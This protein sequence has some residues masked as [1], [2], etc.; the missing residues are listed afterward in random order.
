MPRARE[1]LFDLAG[2]TLRRALISRVNGRDLGETSLASRSTRSLSNAHFQALE[3]SAFSDDVEV[4]GLKI[5]IARF[6]GIE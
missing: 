3:T 5:R 1:R 4:T 2:G 6:N